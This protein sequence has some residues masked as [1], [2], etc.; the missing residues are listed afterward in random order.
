MFLETG[1]PWFYKN[2]ALLK[3]HSLL[4]KTMSAFFAI[5]GEAVPVSKSLPLVKNDIIT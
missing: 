2:Q 5:P 3:C 1:R 4:K